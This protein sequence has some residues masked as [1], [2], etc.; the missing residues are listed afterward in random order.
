MRDV[1]LQ[2]RSVACVFREQSFYM[3]QKRGVIPARGHQ[4]RMLLWR[5]KIQRFMKQRL[6]PLPTRAVHGSMRL[7]KFVCEPSFGGAPVAQNGRFGNF[8]QRR[9]FRHIQA[10]EEAAFHHHGLPRIHA[11]QLFQRNIER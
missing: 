6:N 2:Q 5:G 8:E 7:S 9:G 4:K 10:A 3:G 11:S 1:T